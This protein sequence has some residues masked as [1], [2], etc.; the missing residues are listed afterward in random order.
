[1]TIN[2]NL[3][4]TKNYLISRWQSMIINKWVTNWIK[5]LQISQSYVVCDDHWASCLVFMPEPLALIWR[6]VLT[7]YIHVW[8][9]ILQYKSTHI[10]HE[11]QLVLEHNT[12]KLQQWLQLAYYPSLNLVHTETGLW[13]G[14]T[15][16]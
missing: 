16:K 14:A 6:E 3:R 12:H 4:Q 5:L 2:D 13:G 8:F 11:C 1:M 7:A 10:M 15:N 9:Q